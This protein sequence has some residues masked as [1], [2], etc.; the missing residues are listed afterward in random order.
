MTVVHRSDALA[1]DLRAAW[2]PKRLPDD[3]DRDV[4]SALDAYQG[5]RGSKDVWLQR[6]AAVQRVVKAAKALQVTMRRADA[7]FSLSPSTKPKQQTCFIYSK[8]HVLEQPLG[9]MIG[10]LERWLAW[11]AC[12]QS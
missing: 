12:G 7:A 2:H 9:D 11:R 3:L 6:W 5:T 10:P 1:R 8:W 4:A